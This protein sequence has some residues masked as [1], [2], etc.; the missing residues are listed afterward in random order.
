M[1]KDLI[2]GEKIFILHDFLSPAECD[3]FI[4]QSEDE[5]FRD[6]PL[7]T[8]SGAVMRSDIR[9]NTRVIVDD[10]TLAARLFE[11][12][13]PFLRAQWLG[14]DLLGFNERFRFYRYEAGQ[15]FHK[16]ADGAFF[17]GDDEQSHFTFLI[18]LNDDFQGG[19]TD[20]FGDMGDLLHSVNPVRGEALVFWHPQLHEGATVFSGQKYVLRTDVMYRWE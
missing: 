1:H 4:R 16:H 19:H 6:A 2:S 9:N 12:A 5:G 18:Y 11:R 17:R 14:W 15:T 20:F 10:E 8:P 13:K 3:E 7:S